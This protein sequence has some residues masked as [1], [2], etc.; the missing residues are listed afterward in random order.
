MK[1][2]E[3]ACGEDRL[4]D[5]WLFWHRCRKHIVFMLSAVY[6]R[7]DKVYPLATMDTMSNAMLRTHHLLAQHPD[8][9]DKLRHEVVE[10]Q[11]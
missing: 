8:I 9:Q 1:A 6:T 4:T 11:L 5:N 7:P 10:A 2:N 3:E